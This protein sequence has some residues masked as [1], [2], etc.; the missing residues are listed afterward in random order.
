MSGLAHM[1]KRNW[2]P[3]EKD[4]LLRLKKIVS[5]IY[6]GHLLILVNPFYSPNQHK[7]QSIKPES[8]V[9]LG[10]SIRVG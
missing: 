9:N 10:I 7:L 2:I 4:K 6:I 1:M 3:S 8:L 5:E